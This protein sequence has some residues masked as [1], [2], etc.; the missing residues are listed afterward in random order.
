MNNL[1]IKTESAEKA[2]KCTPDNHGN[3]SAV[4]PD[5]FHQII[6]IE[7]EVTYFLIQSRSKNL[8]KLLR[9]DT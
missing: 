8:P 1:D 5:S 7:K 4:G 9:N 2:A 3:R 6:K